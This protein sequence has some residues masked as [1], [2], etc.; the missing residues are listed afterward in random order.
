MSRAM[1]AGDWTTVA[2]P[3]AGKGANNLLGVASV[4]DNNVWSVGSSFNTQ[5]SAYRTLIEH[6]DGTRWSIVRS[7]DAN[8][9]WNFLNDIAVTSAS[10]IWA[11]GQALTGNFYNTLIERWNGRQ[12]QIIPSPNVSGV[13]NI[14]QGLSVIS[15]NDVWAVGYTQIS[16][17]FKP[18]SLHWDGAAWSIVATPGQARLNSVAGVA[19]NDVWA[20]G[21]TEPAEQSLTMHWNGN[22][23]STVPSPNDSTEDNILWGVS[24]IASND[25]WAVGAAGSLKTLGIHWDGTKWNL[26]PT[27][28]FTSNVSNE[29][30]VG[31]VARSSTDIW[32]VGQF[33]LPLL[34][35]AEQTLTEHWDGTS[36]SVIASPNAKNSNNRLSA[37]TVTPNGT[38]WSVGTVGVF[39]KAERTLTLTKTP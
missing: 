33:L 31:I 24:A 21:V 17:V 12:W 9:S 36:W 27:P 15:A 3:S 13:S 34:G 26:V 35:S 6:W 37:V 25:V 2:S 32:A 18:L 4:D 7:P 22:A 20:V 10:D 19:T 14:L 29:V 28:T 38:L 5:L 16:N 11:V 8:T 1:R 39:G 23:W 30:L